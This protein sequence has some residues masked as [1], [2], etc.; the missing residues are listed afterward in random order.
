MGATPD[1]EARLTT[2]FCVYFSDW[3]LGAWAGLSKSICC[4]LLL[5]VT[6]SLGTHT[7]LKPGFD[8][9]S[10]IANS[11]SLNHSLLTT[12]YSLLTTQS[13]LTFHYSL[14]SYL[15]TPKNVCC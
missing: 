14:L 7:P 15:A 1:R 4:E 12:H 13:P 9:V 11:M 8:G 5:P 3:L 10:A 2:L 6:R